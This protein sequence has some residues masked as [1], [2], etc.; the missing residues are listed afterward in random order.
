MR[1][2]AWPLDF[3]D[4][5]ASQGARRFPRVD[6]S[7]PKYPTPLMDITSTVLKNNDIDIEGAA[8]PD[9]ALTPNEREMLQEGLIGKGVLYEEDGSPDEVFVD[10][11]ALR[12]LISKQRLDVIKAIDDEIDLFGD[13]WVND[14]EG[15]DWFARNS[16]LATD[17]YYDIRIYLALGQMALHGWS[18]KNC[19]DAI[20]PE[21]RGTESFLNVIIPA[22]GDCVPC[23][24]PSPAGVCQMHGPEE[25]M[26]CMITDS[27]KL[28]EYISVPGMAFWCGGH[29]ERERS[30]PAWL[31]FGQALAAHGVCA[32]YARFFCEDV[33]EPSLVTTRR[34]IDFGQGKHRYLRS[35]IPIH[36]EWT[37]RATR[38]YTGLFMEAAE[39]GF[40]I[41]L[42]DKFSRISAVMKSSYSDEDV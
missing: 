42:S 2:K 31:E 40:D 33:L 35:G 7:R 24:D 22:S 1:S 37:S 15:L 41:H 17:L 39:R 38:V 5:L 28:A 3:D 21:P 34:C 4:H 10:I 9:P 36:D 18:Q 26:K 16:G 19:F 23:S 29:E 8:E 13:I 6:G 12:T 25:H 11:G 14:A 30:S 32:D 27:L 20:S